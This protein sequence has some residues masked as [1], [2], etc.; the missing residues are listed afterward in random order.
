M[1]FT[2]L[3]LLSA[4]FI[5]NIND[6]SASLALASSADKEQECKVDE[7]GN[8]VCEANLL[9]D[10]DD[11]YY[12]DDDFVLD[13][14]NTSAAK[15]E[16]DPNC[17]DTHELCTKDCLL[18]PLENMQLLLRKMIHFLISFFSFVYFLMKL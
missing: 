18:A 5:L 4:F 15:K 8:Q 17:I 10:D 11:E 12:D 9:D 6:P 2:S 13:E 1:K 3:S 16:E 7:N 14:D